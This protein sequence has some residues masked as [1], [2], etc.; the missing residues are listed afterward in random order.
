[1]EKDENFFYGLMPLFNQNYP[2]C[3]D[4]DVPVIQETPNQNIFKELNLSTR[5]SFHEYTVALQQFR[6]EVDLYGDEEEKSVI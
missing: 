5:C 6:S 1:M 4:W 2:E 3:I